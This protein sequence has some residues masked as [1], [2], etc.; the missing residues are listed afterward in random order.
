MILYLIDLV[1]FL[2]MYFT[3]P[4]LKFKDRYHPCVWIA[5]FHN[6]LEK[7]LYLNRDFYYLFIYNY[8]LNQYYKL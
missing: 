2:I 5:E 4:T 8:Y 6:G 7:K 1:I 3:V